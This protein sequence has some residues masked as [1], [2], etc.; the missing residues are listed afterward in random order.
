MKAKSDIQDAFLFSDA[1]IC[2]RPEEIPWKPRPRATL[3]I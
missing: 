1:A 3:M 2:K